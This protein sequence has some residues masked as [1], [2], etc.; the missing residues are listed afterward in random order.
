M[1]EVI[2]ESPCPDW[3]LD[4]PHTAHN[5]DAP[6]DGPAH[7]PGREARQPAELAAVES[8][9]TTWHRGHTV[10]LEVDYGSLQ[11]RV[12]CPHDGADLAGV[13]WEDRPNCRQP[14]LDDG[15]PDRS[16]S[17]M[18]ASAGECMVALYVAEEMMNPSADRVLAH[19][20]VDYAWDGP[21]AVELRPVSVE[22]AGQ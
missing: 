22:L 5:W 20:G 7:C 18:S 9:G 2:R 4:V 10:R 14:Y 19:V 21:E 6:V 11:A 17:A 1:T 13:A 16:E 8:D 15:E 12:L 3:S